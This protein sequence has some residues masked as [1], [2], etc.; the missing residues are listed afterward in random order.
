MPPSYA[1]DLGVDADA[2][3]RDTLQPSST[4]TA[5]ARTPEGA[6]HVC[7]DVFWGPL[8]ALDVQLLLASSRHAP[9]PTP[10]PTPHSQLTP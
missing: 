7:L 5:S 1:S 8:R 4:V 3:Y 2:V 6:A 10:S 9:N